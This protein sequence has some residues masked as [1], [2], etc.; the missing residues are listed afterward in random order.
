[1]R[2]MVAVRDMGA[3]LAENHWGQQTSAVLILT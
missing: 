1:V 2:L 3:A